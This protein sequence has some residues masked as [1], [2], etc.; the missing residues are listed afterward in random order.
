MKESDF[1]QNA[2]VNVQR[3]ECFQ[4]NGHR[5]AAVSLSFIPFFLKRKEW[6]IKSSTH[7]A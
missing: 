7:S 5:S 6:M 2:I 1:K 4:K 3:T